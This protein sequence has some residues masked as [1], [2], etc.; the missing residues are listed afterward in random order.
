MTKQEYNYTAPYNTIVETQNE[1][2][3]EITP[4]D[5]LNPLVESYLKDNKSMYDNKGKYYDNYLFNQKFN[6]YVEDA[7]KDRLLKEKVQLYDLNRIDN[8]EIKPYQL[9]LDQIMVNI[10]NVWFNM[11][12]NLVV[13]VNPFVNLTNN[14]IFY[15]A[16]TLITIAL[17]YTALT[18]I[19]N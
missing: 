13:G 7:T 14:D 15:I 16:I 6:K 8:I 5:P 17:F 11:Y 9:P 4:Y 18:Y 10:K 19:F 3:Q 2:S 1:I 12:D